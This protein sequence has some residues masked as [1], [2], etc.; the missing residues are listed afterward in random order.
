MIY[1]S[2]EKWHNC[3]PNE[4]NLAFHSETDLSHPS[5]DF[6][7]EIGSKCYRG[8]LRSIFFLIDATSDVIQTENGI[9]VVAVD[10]KTIANLL[11]KKGTF[12]LLS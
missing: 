10:K 12:P 2:V 7:G 5:E 1:F 3:L 8:L 11:E 6:E 9:L 4:I